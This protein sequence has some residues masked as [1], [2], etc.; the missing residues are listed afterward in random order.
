MASDNL[1][2]RVK[3]NGRNAQREL[4]EE[5]KHLWYT[6]CL[7]YNKNDHDASDVLQNALVNIYTK[8][9]QFDIKKGNFKSW[10]SRIV[11]NECL[12]FIRKNKLNFRI[13]QLE[14]AH[15]LYDENETP[16]EK[17]SAQELIN[18]IQELPTGYQLVFNLYVMEGYNHNE[19][20][21]MLKI[22]VG[23]SKSQL[24]KARRLLKQKLEVLI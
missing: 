15:N 10:S 2:L 12:M 24:F 13:D 9:D 4:Y 7:R 5:Y 1:L 22:S 21:D 19:I 17:L 23:T 11:V 8:I 16:L 6:I 20:S 3:K 14:E 18:L